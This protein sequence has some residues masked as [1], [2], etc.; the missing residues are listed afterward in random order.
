MTVK[1]FLKKP[2]ANGKQVFEYR[3]DA[4]LHKPD[5]GIAGGCVCLATGKLRGNIT[6]TWDHTRTQLIFEDTS[7][8]TYRW[9]D[10]DHIEITASEAAGRS[11]Q[12]P[13]PAS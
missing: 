5:R 9:E 7:H 1:I 10:I 8:V 4:V 12:A 13:R 6:G 2:A 3:E 11:Q